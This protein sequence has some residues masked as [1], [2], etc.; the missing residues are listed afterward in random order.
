MS[1]INYFKGVKNMP[2]ERNMLAANEI[3][4]TL[5]QSLDNHNWHYDKDEQ[6]LSIECGAQGDDLPMKISIKVDTKRNLVLLLSHMPFVI[7]EDKRL[8]VAIAVSAI[9]NRL[10]D[11]C[12]D[13]DVAS[14][15][16]FFRMTNSYIESK[17]GE[18]V[19]T[20]MLFCSCQTIDEYNDKFLMLSKG[21]V[22]IE[23]FL[24]SSSN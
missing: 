10:V 22:S 14:G 20:Y 7:Q 24:S 5:C 6:G 4:A 17:I 13:Y 21:M 12:F 9:N 15:H 18:D 19:F 23:Q 16:I 2:E 1:D 11:G 8:D 3:F